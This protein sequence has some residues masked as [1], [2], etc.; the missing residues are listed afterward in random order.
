MK[1]RNLEIKKLGYP[2]WFNILFFLLTVAAPII[3]ISV[4]G[5]KAPATPSGSAFKISFVGL[6]LGIFTWFF[7][8]RFLIKNWEAKLIASQAALEHDYSIQVGS[9]ELTKYHWYHNESKLSIINLINTVLYGGLTFLI[10]LGISS[11]LIEIKHVVLI[12]TALYVIAFTIKFVLLTVRSG[13][14]V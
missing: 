4:E 7:A 14:D 12:I 2:L 9:P 8:K 10:M 6:S 1:K 11:A 5:L 3:F 13:S